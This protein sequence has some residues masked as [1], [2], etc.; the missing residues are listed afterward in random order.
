[1]E[2]LYWSALAERARSTRAG[3]LSTAEYLFLT[4]CLEAVWLIFSA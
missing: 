2:I 3:N 1:M 4:S